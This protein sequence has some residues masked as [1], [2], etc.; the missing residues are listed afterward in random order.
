[1][2]KENKKPNQLQ[3][4]L[5]KE[6]AQ[7][8][9]SNLAII[10]HSPA[11]FI[12]DFA[13]VLPGLPKANVKARIIMTP[14]HAKTLLMILQ[15]NVRKFEEKYGEIKMVKPGGQGFE[16]KVPKDTLPN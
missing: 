15:D 12:L 16:V 3:I 11:E 1:M 7:G 8:E 14:S 10:T 4:E 5:D 13:Q 9:Y 2:D 6:T